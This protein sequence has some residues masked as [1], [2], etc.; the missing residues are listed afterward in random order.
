MAS[1]ETEIYFI[2]TNNTDVTDLVSTRIYPNILEQGAV[3]P[4][5]TYQQTSGPRDEVMDG[6]SGLVDSS[7]GIIVYSGDYSEVRT[8]AN[9]IRKAL[10]GYSGTADAI[11][12]EAIHLVSESDEPAFPPG[13]D[14]IKRYAK[15]LTFRVWFKN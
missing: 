14:V 8:V 6:P 3:M 5:I 7:F 13:K 4:A 10:D 1:V 12:I 11:E 15:R 2:L 9:V